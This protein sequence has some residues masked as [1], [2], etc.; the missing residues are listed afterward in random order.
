[1]T[2]ETAIKEIEDA[3]SDLEVFSILLRIFGNEH[4]QSTKEYRFG[5]I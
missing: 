1:M 5:T 2:S 4:T 3:R